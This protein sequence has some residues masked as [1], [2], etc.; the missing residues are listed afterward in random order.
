M[1][2]KRLPRRW[3][4]KLF[5]VVQAVHLLVRKAGNQSLCLAICRLQVRQNEPSARRPPPSC[6]PTRRANSG[7]S[8]E[9]GAARVR[10]IKLCLPLALWQ[11]DKSN[12]ARFRQSTSY[13]KIQR[14]AAS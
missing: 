8:R 1:R 3:P 7:S 11:T 6:C 14:Q 10:R 2:Q 5:N 4:L 13:P 12:P 9:P